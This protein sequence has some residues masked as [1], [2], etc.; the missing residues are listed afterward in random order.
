VNGGQA[1]RRDII[2]L[3]NGVEANLLDA[4]LDEE[5]IPH[6]IRSYSDLAF[7]G[8]YQME[9]GWGTVETP[10]EYRDRVRELLAE[11]REN[12]DASAPEADGSP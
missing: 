8:L 7:D 5:G 12:R 2:V 11:L 10:E 4:L 6:Y 3:R 1:R 9:Q